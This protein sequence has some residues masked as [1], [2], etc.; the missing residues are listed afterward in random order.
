VDSLVRG[1]RCL[2]I[3][4]P[5]EHLCLTNDFAFTCHLSCY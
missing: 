3:V 4:A 5:S 2:V 1:G